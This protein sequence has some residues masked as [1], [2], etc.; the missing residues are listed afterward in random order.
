MPDKTFRRKTARAVQ[1]MLLPAVTVILSVIGFLY[2]RTYTPAWPGDFTAYLGAGYAIADGY[3]PYDE[4]EINRCLSLNGL[5]DAEA[6]PFLYSPAFAL[7]FSLGKYLG[8]VWVRRAWFTILHLSFWYGLFL[9][10]R[11]KKQLKKSIILMVVFGSILVFT[12]PYRATAKWGQVSAL[13]FLSISIAIT[14]KPDSAVSGVFL[15]LIPLIKPALSAPLLALRKRAW[16]FLA[17]SILVI[18]TISVAS[19]GF[20]PWRQYA[21]ALNRVSSQWDLSIPGNRS[22]SGNVHR[23]FG[24]AFENSIRGSDNR[25]ERIQRAGVVRTLSSLVSVILILLTVSIVLTVIGKANLKQYCMSGY[26]IPLLSWI[27]PLISPLAY[28]HYGLF[29]LPLLIASIYTEKPVLYTTT[30]AAFI[31]W[32]IVPNGNTFMPHGAA[33]IIVEAV[34]P[35]FLIIAAVLYARVTSSLQHLVK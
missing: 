26:F 14:R 34:R 22:L 5:T 29:L 3:N 2:S 18:I 6:L 23:I 25:Q 17:G 8:A 16:L 28:D 27:S 33:L 11:R 15:S 9:L 21:T 7:P 32:A 31:V 20:E 24:F 10:F 1:T 12:G 4:S 35:L 13:L 30:A 19:T